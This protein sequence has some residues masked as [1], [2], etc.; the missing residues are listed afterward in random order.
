MMRK[1]GIDELLD[2]VKETISI[3]DREY[4]RTN[5]DLSVK[6]LLKIKIKHALEDMR[7]CL[8]YIA[9]DIYDE[10][11]YVDGTKKIAI[12]FPYGKDE[13]SY[14]SMTGRYFKGLESKNEKLYDAIISIQ[15][16]RCG[17]MWLYNLC[18]MTNTNKHED[19]IGQKRITKAKLN[20]A[21]M[22][23]AMFENFSGNENITFSGCNF[24]G[25]E[26]EDD[27]FIKNGK[28]NAGNNEDI[29][30]F[31]LNT[32]FY[33]ENTDINCIKLVKDSYLGISKLVDEVY[34][35]LND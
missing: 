3:I 33:F 12:H 13:N 5:E 20:I 23:I 26:Q 6:E 9:N 18:K 24:N 28:I 30:D 10:L 27:I 19:L 8:D 11:I 15:P 17:S 4:E 25:I 14:K 29:V 22:G 16:F 1:Q 7:S 2:D 34:K 35:I 32:E 31:K 21:G